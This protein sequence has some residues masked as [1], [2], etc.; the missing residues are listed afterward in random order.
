MLRSIST[1][2]Y[3]ASPSVELDITYWKSNYLRCHCLC[4]IPYVNSYN[5]ECIR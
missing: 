1:L 5:Y 3:E 4:T 2:N